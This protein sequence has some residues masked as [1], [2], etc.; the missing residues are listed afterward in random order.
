MLPETDVDDAWYGGAL[1]VLCRAVEDRPLSN[2]E[3]L[4]CAVPN[5]R[6]RMRLAPPAFSAHPRMPPP[7]PPCAPCASAWRLLCACW[8]V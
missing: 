7:R 8:A 1:T 2:G 4:C 5:N 6:V 3:G